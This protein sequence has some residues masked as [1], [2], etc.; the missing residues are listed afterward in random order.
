MAFKQDRES[1]SKLDSYE[2]MQSK[3][4]LGGR[5]RKVINPNREINKE[6][7]VPERRSN[8]TN[9]KGQPVFKYKGSKQNFVQTGKRKQHIANKI[10]QALHVS[11]PILAGKFI[12]KNTD[13][14]Q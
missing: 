1:G 11:V 2:G 13:I 12:K 9:A 14:F 5:P 4:L 8:S 7:R 6:Y 3:G 10:H